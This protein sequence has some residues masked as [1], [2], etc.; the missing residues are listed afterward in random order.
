M[1]QVIDIDEI[2]PKVLQRLF[3]LMTDINGIEF[4]TQSCNRKQ[5]EQ[6]LMTEAVAS[7]E[8]SNLRLRLVI[9]PLRKL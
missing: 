5:S 9:I 3:A 6:G 1:V 2:T 4:Y 7:Y 8:G